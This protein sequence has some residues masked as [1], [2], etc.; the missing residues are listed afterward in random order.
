M[1]K[2]ES[3]ELAN[4]VGQAIAKQRN[5]KGMTQEAVAEA[6]NIGMEAVSRIERGIVM[7]TIA[8]LIEL[9]TIFGCEAADLLTESSRRPEDQ[10]SRMASLLTDLNSADRQLVV[11]LLERLVE[12]LK[13]AK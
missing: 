13:Q 8:R 12:R 10:V 11:E 9:A 5:R 6:L 7:P 3:K 1:S 2:S 4:A